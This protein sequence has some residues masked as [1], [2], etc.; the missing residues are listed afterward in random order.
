MTGERAELELRERILGLLSD[1][2]VERV[3]SAETRGLPDGEEYV[4]LERP[5]EGVRQAHGEA[6]PVG[7]VVPRSAVGDATWGKILT[8]IGDAVQHR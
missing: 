8:G 4:D 6:I 3:S 1:E 5:E 2:E 7:R